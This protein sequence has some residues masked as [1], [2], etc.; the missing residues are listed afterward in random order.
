MIKVRANRFR[1]LS[2]AITGLILSAGLILFDPEDVDSAAEDLSRA[3]GILCLNLAIYCLTPLLRRWYFTYD[4]RSRT[5]T[6]SGRWRSRGVYPWR[7]FDR[8]EYSVY[9][10]G[11]Y[12]V[13][14][15]GKR[16]R[17]PVV[18][19]F[20]DRK[21]WANLADILLEHQAERQ[22]ADRRPKSVGE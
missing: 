7:G 5:V 18:R 17:L 6:A 14:A 16:R 12:E 13:A 2:I 20:A 21:D 4:L 15:S 19:W 9:D 10:A 1:C 3:G 22:D 8:I 11:V